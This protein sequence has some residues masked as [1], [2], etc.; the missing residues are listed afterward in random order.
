MDITK[1]LP[2]G[3]GYS[4]TF[5][6]YYWNNEPHRI[7]LIVTHPYWNNEPTSIGINYPPVMVNIE[8]PSNGKY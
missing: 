3:N 6:P 7:G 8:P 2:P 1:Q 4:K 5:T